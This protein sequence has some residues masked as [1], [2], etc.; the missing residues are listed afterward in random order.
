M[1]ALWMKIV[2]FIISVLAFFGIIVEEKPLTEG[3]TADGRAVMITME[4][5]PS[6]GY[7]WQY[8]VRGNSVEF[9]DKTYKQR[10]GTEGMVGAGG[11]ETFTFN[12]VRPGTSEITFVY[13]R[14]WDPT[15]I[16]RTV[17]YSVTVTENL[18]IVIE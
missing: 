15:S 9:A 12:A 4:A 1:Q 11:T 18:E 7:D 5:N 14:P 16:E 10:E 17:V 6:T 13:Q 8:T 2:A 3:I